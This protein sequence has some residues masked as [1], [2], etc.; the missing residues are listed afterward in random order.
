MN[1]VQFMDKFP[2]GYQLSACPLVPMIKL[3]KCRIIR[4]MMSFFFCKQVFCVFSREFQ[5]NSIKSVQCV[6][7]FFFLR[8]HRRTPPFPN[9]DFETELL[10][11]P[12]CFISEC[13]FFFF[14]F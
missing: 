8:D 9:L 2:I 14:V 7:L 12:N 10:L 13:S 5:H 3:L 6:P 1:I 11:F 4:Y